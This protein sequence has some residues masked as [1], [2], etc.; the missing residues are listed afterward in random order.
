MPLMLE[1]PSGHRLKVPSKM[2]GLNI[3]CPVCESRVAVPPLEG[4]KVQ[5]TSR[6]EPTP[7]PTVSSSANS[8][9]SSAEQNRDHTEEEP[10]IRGNTSASEL[11]S[12]AAEAIEPAARPVLSLIHI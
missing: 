9:I 8:A 5:G 4:P 6:V 1:C 10:L 3:V 11:V 7:L 2:A 12:T